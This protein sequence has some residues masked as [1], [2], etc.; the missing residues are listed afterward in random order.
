MLR[1]SRAYEAQQGSNE[2]LEQFLRD[3]GVAT[4]PAYS[5]R[6]TQGTLRAID[7]I[8][9]LDQQDGG[10]TI[11][12]GQYTTDI[13]LV[14]EGQAIQEK[15]ASCNGMRVVAELLMRQLARSRGISDLGLPEATQIME[16]GH[17]LIGG[18][19]V[20]VEDELR[21][22]SRKPRIRFWVAPRCA[23]CTDCSSPAGA[24]SCCF[25]NWRRAGRRPCFARSRGSPSPRDSCAQD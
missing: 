21:A 11:E 17:M 24:R 4:A 23:G 18:K 14:A 8:V 16:T 15:Y 5:Y 10:A 22:R 12:I 2:W 20:S 13:C 7:Y 1:V 6:V 9:D 19:P 25:T 3:Y